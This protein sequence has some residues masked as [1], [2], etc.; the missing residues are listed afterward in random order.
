MWL[1]DGDSMLYIANKSTKAKNGPAC[2]MIAKRSNQWRA[3]VIAKLP[4]PDAE[5]EYYGGFD[6]TYSVPPKLS[7]SGAKLA[8]EYASGSMQL[9]TYSNLIVVVDMN[10]HKTYSNKL[11]ICID[12]WWVDENRIAV[13]TDKKIIVI[14]AT[15]KKR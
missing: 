11:D 9:D 15:G 5:L 3:E 12:F 10:T 4:P 1:Y 7:P 14:P 8:F 2:L 13:Q 6:W